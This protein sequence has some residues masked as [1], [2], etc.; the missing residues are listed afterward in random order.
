MRAQH[1]NTSPMPTTHHPPCNTTGVV[2]KKS[3]K[4]E[5]KKGGKAKGGGGSDSDG[6]ND[7][8]APGGVRVRPG[9][10]DLNALA[11]VG[12]AEL[13]AAGKRI[14]KDLYKS[15]HP[16]VEALT[17]DK[18]SELRRQR[19][20]TVEGVGADS[21]RFKPLLSFAHTQLSAD[22]LHAT[23]EFTT[24]SPIQ[25]QCWPIILSGRDLIGIAATGSGKTLGFGL[26]ML[27]HI[28]AQRAAGVVGKAGKG[29]Y[30]L[31]MAPTRELALQ[32]NQVGFCVACWDSGQGN[33]RIVQSRQGIRRNRCMR[34][35]R[36]GQAALYGTVVR[37]GRWNEQTC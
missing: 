9:E 29:P 4:A 24:P 20:T 25:A 36:G 22:M 26:P 30:A 11:E 33:G 34:G 19:A 28:A 17:A 2:S 37:H 21:P 32:I 10:V 8:A 14:V 13:A 1:P 31:A 35:S 3:K 5:G 23:R 27:A 7:A 12:S 6:G 16:E 15:L 18:V